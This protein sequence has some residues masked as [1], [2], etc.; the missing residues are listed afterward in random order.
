MIEAKII[1]NE[2]KV[3]LNSSEIKTEIV[4]PTILTEIT[5][6][7]IS[8]LLQRP[9]IQVEIW[10]T[11]HYHSNKNVLDEI[12]QEDLNTIRSYSRS[13]LVSMRTSEPIVQD[14][15]AWYTLYKYTYWTQNYYRKVPTIYNPTQDIFYSDV[16]MTDIIT[17]RA[18]SL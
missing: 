9:I 8:V 3:N 13:D 15:Q 18:L 7:E 11:A 14:T 6:N 12:T 2:I 1:Q 4:N 16:D 10:N 17:T 5:K